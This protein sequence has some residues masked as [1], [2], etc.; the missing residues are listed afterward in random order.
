MEQAIEYRRSEPTPVIEKLSEEITN[1]IVGEVS[2]QVT[3]TLLKAVKIRLT[4]RIEDTMKRLQEDL[5]VN[6]QIMRE[7]NNL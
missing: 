4:N 3:P 5:E 7:L 2:P 1:L 6:A